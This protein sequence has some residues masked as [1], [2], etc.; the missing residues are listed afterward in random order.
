MKKIKKRIIALFITVLIISCFTIAI[1][2]I[3]NKKMQYWIPSYLLQIL[4]KEA[5]I[6]NNQPMHI[7]FLMVDH[8][9]PSKQTNVNVWTK[10]YPEIASKYS[11]SNGFNPQ[12]TWFF[13]IEQKNDIFARQISDLCKK[14]YGEIQ[15]HL[16]HLNDTSESL[17]TKILEGINRYQKYGI[18]ITIDDTINFGFV[19]GN[20]A[21]DNSVMKSGKNMCGVNNELTVLK[22][23][24][25]FADFTF[26][27]TGSMAQPMKINSIYYAKD[28]QLSSKSYNTGID[29]NVGKSNDQ[30]LMIIEGP[31]TLDWSNF[32]NQGYPNIENAQLQ[33][34]QLPTPKRIDAW[35]NNRIHVKGKMNWI[36]IKTYTHGASPKNWKMLFEGGGFE[37]MFSYLQ[38]K[39]N[40][41][42]KYILHYVTARETYNIIKA[43]EIGLKGDPSEFR[44]FII[45]PYKNQLK[46]K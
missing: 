1:N 15:M 8:F 22:S 27:A 18:F 3:V 44:D 37:M 31:L 13:P 39:Y 30:D 45:K 9:E 6:E 20:W 28:D 38:K 34:S 4:T 7:M 21:L 10:R 14:G 16:H 33:S 46:K 40:D 12:Y 43:A 23:L 32:F 24:G 35:V 2:L 19:H 11:D 5:K 29:V 17:K 36:F 41:G 42:R 26:P 25:C